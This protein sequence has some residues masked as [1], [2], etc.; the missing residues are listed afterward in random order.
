MRREFFL[1]LTPLWL[2]T[3]FGASMYATSVTWVV[4]TSALLAVGLFDVLQKKHT[5]LRNFPVIGRLRY[6]TSVTKVSVL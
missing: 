6:R 2:L 3:I 4:L 5:I 1:F